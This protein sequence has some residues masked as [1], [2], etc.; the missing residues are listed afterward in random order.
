VALAVADAVGPP[1]PAE[2]GAGGE[3]DPP[4]PAIAVVGVGTGRVG[5]CFAAAACRTP[6]MARGQWV[7]HPTTASVPAKRTMATGTATGNR[8]DRPR[9]APAVVSYAGGPGPIL[10]GPVSASRLSSADSGPE[11]TSSGEPQLRQ[12]RAKSLF[13]SP[14]AEHRRLP[15]KAE[16]PP[17]AFQDQ[18][19][20]TLQT[21]RNG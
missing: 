18:K 7:C 20:A 9:L 15:A 4:D 17:Q 14:H 19:Y 8:R 5:I 2:L 3:L 21:V 11:E 12:K 1:D 16:T 10:T 13:C 6:K